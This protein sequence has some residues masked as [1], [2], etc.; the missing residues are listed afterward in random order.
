MTITIELD[1]EPKGKERPRSRVAW[2]KD[3]RPFIAIYTPADTRQYE[4]ALAWAGHSN[5][6][7]GAVVPGFWMTTQGMLYQ[8]ARTPIN[9]I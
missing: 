8:R 2:T 3:G 9:S 4:T 7:C 6:S 1:G 5:C